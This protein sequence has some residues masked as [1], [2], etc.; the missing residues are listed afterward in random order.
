MVF[1]A[2]KLSGILF[3]FEY[4][5]TSTLNDGTI[6]HSSDSIPTVRVSD[7]GVSLVVVVVVVVSQIL[8][9]YSC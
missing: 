3:T 2:A 5:N 9:G 1:S 7:L 8:P 6:I 4:I